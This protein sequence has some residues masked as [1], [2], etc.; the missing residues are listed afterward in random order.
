MH[1]VACQAGLLWDASL[2][3]TAVGLRLFRGWDYWVAR[4]TAGQARNA[5]EP[6]YKHQQD[7]PRLA[8]M[9]SISYAV[10][11]EKD[12]ALKEAERAIMDLPTA[13]R[14]GRRTCHG[15][16]SGVNSDDRRRE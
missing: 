15:R 10:L 2:F 9:L 11:G 3:F 13:E 7:N 16:E 4:A 1:F 5:L 6:L 12:A 8:A 14:C